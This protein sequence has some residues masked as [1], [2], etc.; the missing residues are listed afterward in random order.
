MAAAVK[1]TERNLK[2][3]R[4]KCDRYERARTARESICA[5]ASIIG[6]RIHAPV[7]ED[8]GPEGVAVTIVFSAG[9]LSQDGSWAQ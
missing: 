6:E 3:L 5:Q 7:T 1:F 2:T 8:E 9:M 4:T